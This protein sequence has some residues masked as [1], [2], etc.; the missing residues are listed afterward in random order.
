MM[1]VYTLLHLDKQ[2][3]PVYEG[4]Y[5]IRVLANATKTLL[6]DYTTQVKQLAGS[7]LKSSGLL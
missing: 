2:I 1:A 3:I 6:G 5:D 7:L 4:Q